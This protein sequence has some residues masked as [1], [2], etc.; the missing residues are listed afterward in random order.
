MLGL[1]FPV[2]TDPEDSNETYID[3]DSKPGFILKTWLGENKYDVVDEMFVTDEEWE[4][5]KALNEPLQD[6]VVECFK[7]NNKL[8]RY[9]RFRDDKDNGNHV[10]TYHKVLASIEDGVTKEE[11]IQKCPQIRESWKRREELKRQE[12]KRRDQEANHGGNPQS[13][14]KRSASEADRQPK[15]Q[16]SQGSPY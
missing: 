6:R 14:H 11:L 5:F 7:D 12:A 13:D 1:E 9:M 4:K 16:K 3:Y 2:Y 8:W 15:R 10:G